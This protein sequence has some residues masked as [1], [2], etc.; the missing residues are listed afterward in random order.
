MI[1]S[2][3]GAVSDELG[4]VPTL[5]ELR[6]LSA[7][8]SAA[9]ADRVRTFL[10]SSVSRTGGHLGANLSSVELTIA[11]HRVFRSPETTIIWDTGHQSYTHKILTGRWPEFGTLRSRHGLSG[12][13]SRA[14]SPHDL[15]ENSHASVG[16]AWA[17]GVVSATRQPVVMVI[18]DGALTGGVAFEGLNAIGHRQA[19]V[20]VVVNDNGRSYAAT[21]SRLTYGEPINPERVPDVDPAAFFR[22]LGFTSHGPVDG[23]D[24]AALDEVLARAE[25]GPLPCVVYVRTQKGYGLSAAL[26]DERKRWHDIAPN[27]VLHAEPGPPQVSAAPPDWSTAIGDLL[28]DWAAA[29]DRIHAITAAMPDTLG[30]TNFATRFPD[31]YHDLGIAEQACVA[32]AAGLASQG[33]RPIFSIITTFLARGLDQVLYDVAM[34]RLPVIFLLDRAGVTGPDGPSHHGIFDVGLIRN[35]PGAEI[36]SPAT[37]S[38]VDDVLRDA[39]GR[40]HGPLFLRYPKGRPAGPGRPPRGLIRAGGDACLVAHGATV[41]IALAA[42]DLLRDRDGIECAVWRVLRLHPLDPK[43]VEYASRSPLLIP[44]EDVAEPGGLAHGLAYAVMQ[45][46]HRHVRMEPLTLPAD[47]MPHGGRDDLLSEVGLTTDGLA[48]FVLKHVSKGHSRVAPEQRS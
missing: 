8:E 29:D 9:L 19:P 45:Q 34:H 13:P 22:S 38:D 3:T 43:L 17:Y 46:G 26:A 37:L 39:L 25:R 42:A 48:D 15:L 4:M 16:P 33:K 23:H 7:A 32:V 6:R 35:V 28:C 10:V 14:E 40:M 27:Q 5:D 24:I 36:Y 47:F 41:P 11:L 30:L 21:R 18:G 2:P 31:R 1:T 20:I 12:F 44:V